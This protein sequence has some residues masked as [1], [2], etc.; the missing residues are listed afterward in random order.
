[1]W[2][3]W[4]NR[5]LASD[6]AMRRLRTATRVVLAVALT[7][8]VVLPVLAWWGQP[9]PLAMIGAVVAINSSLGV[10][11]PDPR[12]QRITTLLM[13]LPVT[14]ALLLA[15]LTAPWPLVSTLVFLVVIF[16]AVYVR[17]FGPRYFPLGMVAFMGYFFAMFLRPQLAQLPAL[18]AA[19]LA[20]ALAAFALR[21]LVLRDEPEG[22]LE[23]GRR[24]L[25]AQVHGLLHAVR[26]VAE[27]PDSAARRR[28]LNNRSVRLNETALMLEGA[29]GQLDSLDEAGRDRLRQ[30]IL[31]VEL[32]AENL[33]T[34]LLRLVDHPSGGDTV[35]H[36]VGALLAVLRTDPRE[37]REATRL[38]AERIEQEGSVA[39]A[40]A[41]RRLGTCLAELA[42]ATAEFDDRAER[43]PTSAAEP[44]APEAGETGL[45]RPEVRMAVQVTCAT[46]LAIMLGQLVSPN[47]W[48]WA[49][50]TAFVVFIS[51]NS[52][53]ELLV[54]AWQRTAGTVLGVLAGMLVAAQISGNLAAEIVMILICVFLGFYFAGFSYAVMTF[55]ITALLGALYGMLGTFDASVLETRLWETAVG[56]LAGVLAAVFVLPTRTRSLVRDNTE[57]FLLA[58]RDFL[59]GTGTELSERG[60][61]T[62]LQESMREL[63]DGLQRVVRSARPL[64]S[65]RLR[66]RRSQVQRSV[67][68]LSGCAYY[69]RNLAVALAATAGMVDE[70]TR[71]RLSELLWALADAVEAMTGE[72]QVGFDSAMDSA[73]R[74]ADSLHDIAESLTDGPTSLHRTIRWLDRTTRI[75][76]DLARELGT[77]SEQRTA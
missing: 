1:M 29:V 36:A 24:T 64:T 69:V 34:P 16:T 30:R 8:V 68:M 32:A 42:T 54:R 13:P 46:A 14:A 52:R 38:V 9:L 47:R 63:D 67:T 35:P 20:G 2:S 22:V 76:E 28:E 15:M 10:N 11:D 49:V 56:A 4:W 21:F 51:T 40:M 59:R 5:F 75:V 39:I 31:D 6:P 71:D 7:I 53:G 70:D 55:F 19:A 44:D 74:T 17:R 62:G 77:T 41:V 25:L 66:S 72:A 60:E 23:R 33:L 48:Y 27:H 3:E 18:F 61:V 37:L 57:D 12:Q 45:Q 50:I 58:L 26:D 73:H 43:E 65:Y